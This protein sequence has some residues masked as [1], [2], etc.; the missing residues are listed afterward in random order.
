MK[1]ISLPLTIVIV[2]SQISLAIAAELGTRQPQKPP[3]QQP[4]SNVQKLQITP[5]YLYQQISSLKQQVG[6]LQAQNKQV[7][8]LKKQVQILQSQ[9]NLLRSVVQVSA[10]S[11]TIQAPTLTI[12]T[13]KDLTITSAQDLVI[14]AGDDFELESGKDLSFKGGK[15]VAAEGAGT[16]KLKAPQ[17]KLND[18]TKSVA[19]VTSSVSGGKVVS[20]STSVF[21]P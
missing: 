1:K 4:P 11:T 5:E 21:V 8:P 16:L 12:N 13:A 6:A 18:G 7:M 14:T 20:G 19:H 15:D 2:L 10:N 9:V 17:I 3:M